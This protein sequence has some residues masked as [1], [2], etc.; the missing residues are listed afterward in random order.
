MIAFS[1]NNILTTK[2]IIYHKNDVSIIDLCSYYFAIEETFMLRKQVRHEAFMLQKMLLNSAPQIIH[3]DFKL[4]SK[5][6]TNFRQ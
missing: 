4:C 6:C 2:T 3:Y 5:L 1:E